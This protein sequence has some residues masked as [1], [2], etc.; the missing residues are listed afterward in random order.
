MP[1]PN[2]FSTCMPPTPLQGEPTLSMS[3]SDKLARWALLGLQGSLLGSL[4]AAPIRLSTL[5]VGLPPTLASAQGAA[6]MH[7]PCCQNLL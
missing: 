1:N 6:Q 7:Q 4:L 3:C 5:T 2:P